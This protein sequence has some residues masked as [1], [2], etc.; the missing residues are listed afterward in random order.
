METI[1]FGRRAGQHAAEHALTRGAHANGHAE[2]ARADAETWV[3]E[4]LA[5]RPAS[6]R[7]RS[8]TSS[9][10]RCSRTSASSGYAEKMEK[11]IEVI[12]ELARALR[13]RDLIEDKGSIFNSDLT[14]AIE[15]G[16]LLDLAAVHAPGRARAAGE[17]RRPLA[18]V[19]LPD[20][21]RRELPQALDH[22]LGDGGPRAL[23]R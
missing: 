17:A 12:G 22:A 6:G 16:Y 20:P 4:L 18:P 14:Q 11:Q 5:A 23:V 8:A 10:S 15:L 3:K 21:R 2:A 1:T 13:A 19:R 7:G 9:A